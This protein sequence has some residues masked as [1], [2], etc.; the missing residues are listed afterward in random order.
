MTT[1]DPA[2]PVAG[3]DR[4]PVAVLWDMDGTLVDTEPYWM[5]TEHELAARTG[6][7]WTA[8]QALE[9]VGT[10]LIHSGRILKEALGLPE[11]PEEVVC[12]LLD[13]VVAKVEA[14]VPWQPGAREILTALKD[15]GVPMALVTMSYQRFVDPILADLPEGT[16]DVVVTGDAVTRGKPD[17]EP[18]LVAARMLGV[19]PADCVAVEDSVPGCTSA[20]AAGCAVLAVPA[21]VEVPP[22]PDRLLRESLVGLVPADLGALPDQLR[23]RRTA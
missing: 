19:D 21:H 22:H 13:G 17:P 14:A 3:G 7:T 2:A 4:L 15:A 5:D 23:D 9:L 6:A 18:Y 1:P 8:E 16:F 10:A 11:S 20:Q 12:L